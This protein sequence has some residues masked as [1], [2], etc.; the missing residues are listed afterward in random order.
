MKFVCFLI[1]FSLILVVL[2]KVRKTREKIEGLIGSSF[3]ETYLPGKTKGLYPLGLF[4]LT[5][6]IFDFIETTSLL[7][8]LE[9]FTSSTDIIRQEINDITP[10]K[11]SSEVLRSSQN[12]NFPKTGIIKDIANYIPFP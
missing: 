4:I 9:D 3:L 1:L 10:E 11:T 6:S 5:I 12:L 7:W 2:L 8:S